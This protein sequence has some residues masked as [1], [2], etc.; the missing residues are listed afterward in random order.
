MLC[1]QLFIAYL[2]FPFPGTKELLHLLTHLLQ[3]SVTFLLLK[4]GQ[5]EAFWLKKAL[6]PLLDVFFERLHAFV[7]PE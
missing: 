5:L 1:E 6:V 7:D 3:V 4:D 2:T